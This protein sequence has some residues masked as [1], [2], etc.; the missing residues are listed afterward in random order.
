MQNS[1]KQ[2]EYTFVEIE[3]KNNHRPY[4]V[5][6]V[7]TGEEKESAINYA[8]AAGLLLGI[9]EFNDATSKSNSQN[10]TY[11][12]EVF[13]QLLNRKKS[14]CAIIVKEQIVPSRKVLGC[15]TQILDNEKYETT[16]HYQTECF[17]VKVL[18]ENGLTRGATNILIT[19]LADL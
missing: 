9:Y 8:D 10:E 4:R 3:S 13:H 17:D 11:I 1:F 5:K 6:C 14:E 19:K 7:E 12:K 2:G 18:F 15:I 16:L